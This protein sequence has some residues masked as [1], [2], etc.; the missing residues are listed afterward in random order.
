MIEPLP[1]ACRFMS[2]KEWV[3]GILHAWSQNHVYF[4]ENTGHFPVGIVEDGT[5]SMHIIPVEH[6]KMEK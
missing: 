1:R 6:I 4:H 5:G 3:P 2:G